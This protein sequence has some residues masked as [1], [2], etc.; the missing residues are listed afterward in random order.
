MKP[1]VR[2]N[3][4]ASTATRTPKVFVLNRRCGSRVKPFYGCILGPIK[5]IWARIDLQIIH[6]GCDILLV[7]PDGSTELP[8]FHFAEISNYPE[9]LSGAKEGL[10]G[11]Q[12]DAVIREFCLQNEILN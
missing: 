12:P 5:A 11:F 6:N 1:L 9:C 2:E 3:F 10:T 7:G 4:T 8:N